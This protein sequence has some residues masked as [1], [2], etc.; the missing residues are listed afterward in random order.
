[1]NGRTHDQNETVDEGFRFDTCSVIVFYLAQL[2][3]N[4]FSV[5]TFLGVACG[6]GKTNLHFL[7]LFFSTHVLCIK[8]SVIQDVHSQYLWE[9]GRNNLCLCSEPAGSCG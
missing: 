5:R 9:V 1:M 6:G 7:A 4:T 8:I 3:Y 2:N